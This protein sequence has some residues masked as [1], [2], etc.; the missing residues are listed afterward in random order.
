MHKYQSLTNFKVYLYYGV[1][2]P[3]TH[4]FGKGG[5]WLLVLVKGHL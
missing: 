5:W 4:R 1:Q 3:G 2:G